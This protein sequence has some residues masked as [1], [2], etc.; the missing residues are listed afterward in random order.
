MC[1]SVRQLTFECWNVYRASRRLV[2]VWRCRLPRNIG[3]CWENTLE[4]LESGVGCRGFKSREQHSRRATEALRGRT[5]EGKRRS[6]NRQTG[7]LGSQMKMR[8]VCAHR[9]WSSSSWLP[10]LVGILHS[11]CENCWRLF[12]ICNCA[13]K[14]PKEA[15]RQ[16]SQRLHFGW[17]KK[18]KPEGTTALLDPFYG[19][20][21]TQ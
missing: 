20:L 15:K 5:T 11:I 14:A 16:Q 19:S 3:E 8:R 12:H 17:M 7:R 6:L 2:E 21:P 9:L 1:I 4:P 18:K 10:D 13:T